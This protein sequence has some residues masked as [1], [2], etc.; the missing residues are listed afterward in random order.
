MNGHEQLYI[1]AE[2]AGVA[3]HKRRTSKL[4][5]ETRRSGALRDKRTSMA[6]EETTKEKATIAKTGSAET[7]S[8]RKR[9]AR[10]GTRHTHPRSLAS[11]GEEWPHGREP[12]RA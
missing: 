9:T 1:P 6:E 11:K 12:R 7:V 3:M 8:G 5:R 10:E 4:A 2:N